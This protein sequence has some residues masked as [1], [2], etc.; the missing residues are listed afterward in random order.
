MDG[1]ACARD[2]DTAAFAAIPTLGEAWGDDPFVEADPYRQEPVHRGAIASGGFQGCGPQGPFCGTLEPALENQG[3]PE[4]YAFYNPFGESGKQ[5]NSG[6]STPVEETEFLRGDEAPE[7][8]QDPFFQLVATTHHVKE[9][10]A[11]LLGNSLLR[12]LRDELSAPPVKLRRAKFTVKVEVEHRFTSWTSA[13]TVK[14]RVY[15]VA[16][17]LLAV[18]FQRRAGDCVAFA[19]IFRKLTQYLAEHHQLVEGSPAAS[20]ALPRQGATLGLAQHPRAVG[21]LSPAAPCTGA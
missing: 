9:R 6:W 21:A 12:F 20:P 5:L 19:E 16:E 18:E 14:L 1:Y 10:E 13:C 11:H 15:R 4:D 17:G 3:L 2:T 8:P 7:L